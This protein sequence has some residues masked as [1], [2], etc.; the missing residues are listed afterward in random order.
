MRGA[1]QPLAHAGPRD[2]M[3]ASDLG[4]VHPTIDSAQRREDV[5]RVVGLP[6]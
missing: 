6:G 4:D 5:P 1:P 2:V 3:P